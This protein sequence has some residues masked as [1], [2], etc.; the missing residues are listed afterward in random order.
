MTNKWV[1]ILT[2]LT[3]GRP[4]TVGSWDTLEEALN[5]AM[6]WWTDIF[7]VPYNRVER[8]G[9]YSDDRY[10]VIEGNDLKMTVCECGEVYFGPSE[11]TDT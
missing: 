6:G 9:K 5:W 8:I 1:V 2:G 4:R 3:D 11:V 7:S 10:A